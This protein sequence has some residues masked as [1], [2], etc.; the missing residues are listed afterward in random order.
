MLEINSEV[1]ITQLKNDMEE[2]RDIGSHLKQFL[3]VTD[4]TE[5]KK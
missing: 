4:L 2:I 5:F 3:E 1:N